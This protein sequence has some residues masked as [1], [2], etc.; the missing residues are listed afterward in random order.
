MTQI[1]T[2]LPQKGD[3]VD[4]RSYTEVFYT[5]KPTFRDFECDWLPRFKLTHQKV[6][7]VGEYFPFMISFTPQGTAHLQEGLEPECERA[8]KGACRHTLTSLPAKT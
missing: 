4:P 3:P 2:E 6:V 8:A 5:F 7:K 1:G